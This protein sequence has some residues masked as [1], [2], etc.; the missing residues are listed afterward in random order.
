[1]NISYTL[2]ARSNIRLS[3]LKRK[4]CQKSPFIFKSTQQR[5][6]DTYPLCGAYPLRKVR[7]GLG[8]RTAGCDLVAWVGM[9]L[10]PS[11]LASRVCIGPAGKAACQAYFRNAERR[12]MRRSLAMHSSG[13]CGTNKCRIGKFV[14]TN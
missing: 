14:K 11:E 12:F 2:D 7:S 3:A 4:L 6:R 13:K 1:M 8:P 9:R 5:H 10:V